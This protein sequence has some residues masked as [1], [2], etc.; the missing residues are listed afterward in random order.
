MGSEMCIR[1]RLIRVPLT[2]THHGLSVSALVSKKH[3]AYYLN[4]IYKDARL[5]VVDV[6]SQESARQNYA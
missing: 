2:N 3:V 6:E 4:W 5:T 1:D